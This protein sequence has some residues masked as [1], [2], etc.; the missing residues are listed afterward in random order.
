[1]LQNNEDTYLADTL[2]TLVQEIG[3]DKQTL[4]DVAAR[5]NLELRGW[6]LVL[7]SVSETVARLKANGRLVGYSPLSRLEEFELLAAGIVT[8]ASLWRNCELSLAQR[9]E[10]TGID[11]T[12]LVRRAERQLAAL[13][14][15]RQR[16]VRDAFLRR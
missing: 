1:M 7:G 8:K 4:E 13:E 15:H 3:E 9:P 11:F 12:G 14:A 6:K 2:R 5:L 10:L 16:V